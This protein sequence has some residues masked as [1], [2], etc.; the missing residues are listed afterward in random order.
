MDRLVHPS[1]CEIIRRFKYNGSGEF[2]PG[3]EEDF[4]IRSE[5]ATIILAIPSS[6]EA[7]DQ[8]FFDIL[9]YINN[10]YDKGVGWGEVMAKSRVCQALGIGETVDRHIIEHE[11]AEH[12]IREGER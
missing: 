11:R 1:D 6:L 5:D 10:A 4:L 7:E 2:L 12:N 3:G 8:V 9:S